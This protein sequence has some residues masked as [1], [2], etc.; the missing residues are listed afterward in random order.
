MNDKGQDEA[1][2]VNNFTLLSINL[3]MS[4]EYEHREKKYSSEIQNQVL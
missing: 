4:S 2:H 3:W 1:K